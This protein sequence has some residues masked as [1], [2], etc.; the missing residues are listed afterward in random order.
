MLGYEAG[1]MLGMPVYN[2]VAHPRDD[3]D[4]TIRR[5]PEQG[6]RGGG[7]RKDRRRGGAG[8][9]GRCGRGGGG[10]VGGG[11]GLTVIWLDGRE[12]FCTVVRDVTERRRVEKA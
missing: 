3:I 8:A 6:R 4:A 12:V 5:T 11:G 2:F 1:E 9:G 10:S 7:R